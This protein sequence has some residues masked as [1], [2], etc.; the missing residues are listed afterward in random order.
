MIEV[1]AAITTGP[2]ADSWFMGRNETET[3][4]G[5]RTCHSRRSA[6]PSR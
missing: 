2:G 4:E 6:L 5:G 1:W 3:P